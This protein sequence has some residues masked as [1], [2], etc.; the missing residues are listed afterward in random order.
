MMTDDREI[1]GLTQLRTSTCHFSTV[2]NM[3]F[4]LKLFPQ[5]LDR[6]VETRL[7]GVSLL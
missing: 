7:G 4:S 1:G 6:A 3:C 2:Q 5:R